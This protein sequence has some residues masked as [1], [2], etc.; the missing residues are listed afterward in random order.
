MWTLRGELSQPRGQFPARVA[1]CRPIALRVS[2]LSH[3]PARPPLRK[4][5]TLLEH[6]DRGTSACR[7]QKFSRA[8]SR[9][10]SRSGAWSGTM[11]LSRGC[12]FSSPRPYGR[13]TLIDSGPVHR[14]QATPLSTASETARHGERNRPTSAL[15]WTNCSQLHHSPGASCPKRPQRLP[16]GRQLLMLWI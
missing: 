14:G 10:A 5:Q 8:T 7:A 9:I 11:R 4:P 13:Q 12:F 2:G 6:V 16:G 1:I 15:L 3:S